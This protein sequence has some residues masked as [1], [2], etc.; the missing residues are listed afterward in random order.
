[1]EE[2]K[3]QEPCDNEGKENILDNVLQ[4]IDKD[5]REDSQKR[6]LE[7]EQRSLEEVQRELDFNKK[8]YE[9]RRN[10]FEKLRARLDKDKKTFTKK[11][12]R[13]KSSK[14][15]AYLCCIFVT[16]ILARIFY[17]SMTVKWE[18][19]KSTYEK[20]YIDWQEQTFQGEYSKI[21]E[22]SSTILADSNREELNRYVISLKRHAEEEFQKES[23]NGVSFYRMASVYDM[24]KYRL[25]DTGNT[26]IFPGAVVKGDSL[27][28]GMASYTLVTQGR[29]PMYLTSNQAGADSVLVEDINYRTVSDVIK[30]YAKTN[31]GNTAKSWDYYMKSI[32]SSDELNF[33]LGVKLPIN[34]ITIDSDTGSKNKN[35]QSYLLVIYTKT[36]YTVSAEPLKS[37]VDYFQVGTDMSSL[38]NYEPAYVSSVDYGEMIIVL[39]Q[40]KMS[41]EELSQK[42]GASI[43]GV[44][45]DA[46]L[47]AIH[48]DEELTASILQSGGKMIDL[49]EI[50]GSTTEST[51]KEGLIDK[52]NTFWFGSEET[53]QQSLQD[54]TNGAIDTTALA[55]NSI[56]IAYTLKYLSDNS[57]VPTKVVQDEEVMLEDTYNY[58]NILTEENSFFGDWFD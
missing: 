44:G 17:S 42:V 43:A 5:G 38:G 23:I 30:E 12:R 14:V 1:M 48:M 2:I 18:E 4:E 28:Q 50:F 57:Y 25:F 35:Q 15:R 22:V 27:L 29:T 21:P 6:R 49:N 52:W 16:L 54:R 33:S 41:S 13:A 20:E 58:N 51:R 36:H 32:N 34:G 39:V 47:S 53:G 9:E 55:E 3:R 24:D 8:Q 7:E 45:I 11:L 46:G 31:E 37:A 19:Y 10:N 40:G 56:P 26:V